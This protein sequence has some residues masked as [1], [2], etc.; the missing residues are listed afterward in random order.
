MYTFSP[1]RDSQ[2]VKDVM[3]HL[4]TSVHTY[5]HLQGTYHS[6]FNGPFPV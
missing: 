6:L 2:S 3:N 1:T 5:F 4:R